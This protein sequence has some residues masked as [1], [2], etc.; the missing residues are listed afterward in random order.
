MLER[1]IYKILEDIQCAKKGNGGA[2]PG[3]I[4]FYG[5]VEAAVQSPLKSGVVSYASH[6]FD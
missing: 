1:K 3:G 5:P 6:I 4:S 2:K